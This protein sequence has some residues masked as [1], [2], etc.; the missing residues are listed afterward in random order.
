MKSFKQVVDD[1]NEENLQEAATYNQVY[2]LMKELPTPSWN[3]LMSD[4]SSALP[5]PIPTD[6]LNVSLSKMVGR[7]LVR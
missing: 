3:T 7:K 2:K 6:T 4:I 1:V 5:K